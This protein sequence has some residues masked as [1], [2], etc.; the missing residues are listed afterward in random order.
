MTI[1]QIAGVLLVAQLAGI[2]GAMAFH[3]C[4]R[5]APPMSPRSA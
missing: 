1:V 2:F 5:A 4:V 3:V